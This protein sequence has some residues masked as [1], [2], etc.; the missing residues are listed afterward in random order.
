MSMKDKR[1]VLSNM[2]K[3]AGW[4]VH[5]PKNDKRS[6]QCSKNDTNHYQVVSKFFIYSSKIECS[7]VCF[8]N[9]SMA[10]L[11]IRF[12]FNHQSS[13]VSCNFDFKEESSSCA[14][15]ISTTS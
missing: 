8:I 7:K 9:F 1:S 3:A 10:L 11:L 2:H 13:S 6:S 4:G 14:C 15:C 12:S 5:S